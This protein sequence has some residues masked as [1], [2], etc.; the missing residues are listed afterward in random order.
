MKA[1][2][3]GAG[4]R[5]SARGGL[6]D[7]ESSEGGGEKR[8]TRGKNGT[9][10]QLFITLCDEAVSTAVIWCVAQSMAP[11]RTKPPTNH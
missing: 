11:T 7:G 9:K 8:D 6:D 3:E 10:G 1:E 4:K 5:E 2:R